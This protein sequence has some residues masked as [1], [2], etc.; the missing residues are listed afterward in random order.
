MGPRGA[1]ADGAGVKCFL[2]SQKVLL[3]SLGVEYN[4]S[5]TLE[6]GTHTFQK[7]KRMTTVI[8]KTQVV[9]TEP[10]PCQALTCV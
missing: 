9:S 4:S 5:K 7:I 1:R 3:E 10:L 2:S 8:L 6:R